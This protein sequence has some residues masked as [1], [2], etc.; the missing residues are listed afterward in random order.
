MYYEAYRLKAAVGVRA[1]LW[2]C[3]VVRSVK[4]KSC[5]RQKKCVLFS[6]FIQLWLAALAFLGLGK[7]R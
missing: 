1:R 3:C 7:Q 2:V 4:E 6:I 5:V